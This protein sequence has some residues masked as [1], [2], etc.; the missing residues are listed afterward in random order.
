[1]L[2]NKNFLINQYEKTNKYPINHNYLK[3]QF[4][5]YKL[6][7]N[8]IEK[9]IKNYKIIVLDNFYT[10]PVKKIDGINT[11]DEVY[12]SNT[13]PMDQDSDGDNVPDY[14]DPQDVAVYSAEWFSEDCDGLTYD[15]EQ[16]NDNYIN[17]NITFH[18]TQADADA[19]VNPIAT[20][21]SNSSGLT[22][23]YVR[24]ENTVSNQVSTNG[25]HKSGGV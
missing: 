22:V 19:N 7:F 6:I 13:N 15:L 24:V 16:F 20:P 11:A 1:M 21:F 17:S 5:D 12:G 3:E 18:E 25:R 4:S 23:L 9:L 2:Q 8:K 10:S 14:L